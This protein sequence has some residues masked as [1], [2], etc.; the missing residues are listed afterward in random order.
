MLD[1]ICWTK[2]GKRIQDVQASTEVALPEFDTLEEAK[3]NPPHTDLW[4]RR[5]I[6]QWQWLCDYVYNDPTHMVCNQLPYIL[7]R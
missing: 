5:P 2:D 6:V 4:N 3:N 1:K 7:F